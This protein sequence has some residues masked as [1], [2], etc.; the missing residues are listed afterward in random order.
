MAAG[1]P[2]ERRIDKRK[3]TLVA[4][5]PIGPARVALFGTA[6]QTYYLEPAGTTRVVV[7]D[8]K[9]GPL[10]I[11]VEPVDGSTLEAVLSAAESVIDSLRF[12]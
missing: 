10:V 12:R 7:V 5:S 4:L 11:A 1:K 6:D 8:G 2:A 9:D 3:A